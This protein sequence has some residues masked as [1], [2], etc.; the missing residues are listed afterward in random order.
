MEDAEMYINNEQMVLISLYAY[1]TVFTITLDLLLTQAQLLHCVCNISVV[2]F[3]LLCLFSIIKIII[4]IKVRLN[5]FEL[6]LLVNSFGLARSLR[7]CNLL[8]VTKVIL[9]LITYTLLVKLLFF[10]LYVC[11]NCIS[12]P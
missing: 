5:E 10:T 2:A 1:L 8:L 3:I 12:S 7:K 9:L 6:L 4:I 11:C